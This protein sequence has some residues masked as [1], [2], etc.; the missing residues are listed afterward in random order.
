[1][2]EERLPDTIVERTEVEIAV[3]GA[4]PIEAK[5]RD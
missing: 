4:E 5:D 1:M 2:A 3:Q